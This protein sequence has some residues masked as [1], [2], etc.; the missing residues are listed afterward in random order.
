[1]VDD[2]P[3]QGLVDGNR[4]AVARAITVVETGGPKAIEL[5]QAVFAHTGSA[6]RVGI[7]GPPGSGKSTLINQLIAHFRDHDMSVAVIAI[8]PT[9]SYTQGAL[10]GDR[11]RMMEADQ[12]SGVFI[13]SMASRDCAGG[14]SYAAHDAANIFDAAGFDYILIETLGVGQSELDI[15]S[16][17]DTVMAVVVPESGDSVQAMKAGLMEIADL[18][19]LNKCD[20]P[21]SD[22]TYVAIQSMLNMPSQVNGEWTPDIVKTVAT[23]GKG[24]GD[25][26]MQI[27]RHRDYMLATDGLRK[28]RQER[29]QHQIRKIVEKTIS[30]ELWGRTGMEQLASSIGLVLDGEL[31]PYELAR[32]IV[33]KYRD[34]STGGC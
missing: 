24:I 18:F 28:R 4:S 13:R 16:V 10:L 30:S 8:D 2:A 12:D 27:L 33:N 22:S 6:Y 26:A 31:S 11:I 1:V 7:T 19:V 5:Q 25:L 14:L 34:S 15:A 32:S 21:D 17:A 20:R 23:V 9:S 3:I 29:L